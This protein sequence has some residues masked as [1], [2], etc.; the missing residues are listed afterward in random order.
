MA[1]GSSQAGS[2]RLTTPPLSREN[3][4][5]AELYGMLSDGGSEEGEQKSDDDGSESGDE[6]D[7]EELHDEGGGK[8]KEKIT[9]APPSAN[10]RP[11]NTR[12]AERS[13]SWADLDL[14]I[15]VAFV[16][17][18][19]NW[20]TGGDHIKN[21]F[22]I[23]LLIFYLHQ[24]IEIPWKL[25][26]SSLPRKPTP[27]IV[28]A[29]AN[30]P[31]ARLAAIA[32]TELRRRELFYLAITVISPLLGAL[33]LQHVTS[34][35]GGE[36]VLSWFSTTLFV[37]ATGIRPWSHLISRLRA[38]TDAL[39]NAVH[40]PPPDPLSD[41]AVLRAQMTRTLKRVTALE[42]ELSTLRAH[43]VHAERLQGVCDDLSE[44]MG[45]LERGAK[46]GERRADSARS[47]LGARLAS[48]EMGLTQ[49]EER[50]RKDVAALKACAP[51]VPRQYAA[52]YTRVQGCIAAVLRA[53]QMLWSLGAADVGPEKSGSGS[54]EESAGTAVSG[55]SIPLRVRGDAKHAAARLA[56]IPE[57]EHSDGDSDGTYVSDH[58]RVAMLSPDYRARDKAR[59]TRSRSRSGASAAPP[60]A[61]SCGQADL[62]WPYRASV[63]V[64]GTVVPPVKKSCGPSWH[65]RS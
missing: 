48:L 34:A 38:R 53:P 3:L 62:L 18:I 35:L 42:R 8:G 16:S 39:H 14:S 17:P 5:D 43:A 37:L 31:N 51:V 4:R 29:N 60:K 22:L 7:V 26:Q 41:T 24:L 65:S 56:T 52:L 47:A 21:L 28:P 57:A 25:Y 54:S 63:H 40:H 30:D 20:L 2:S 10:P 15:I 64:L 45:E 27:S 46:R 58:D 36:R 12:V 50:R 1:N 9:P 61:R 44:A 59:R 32:Q 23:I 19:G 55:N 6:D 49:L 33:F 11:S 13:S